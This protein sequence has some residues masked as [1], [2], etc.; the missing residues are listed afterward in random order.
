MNTYIKI[1]IVKYLSDD[2][3]PGIVSCILIDSDGKDWYFIEKTAIV[4]SD[5][6]DSSWKYP[7]DGYIRG[8][9]IDQIKT[10][11][12]DLIYIIDTKNPDGVESVDGNSVFKINHSQL[13][14]F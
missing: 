1:K 10:N 4:N 2:P 11:T 13:L 12:G 9:V 7:I 5:N 6:I 8:I 14:Q 3:Q